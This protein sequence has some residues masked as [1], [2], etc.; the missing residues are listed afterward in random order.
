AGGLT[1][2]PEA[3]L[4]VIAVILVCVFKPAGNLIWP[5]AFAALYGMVFALGAL[6]FA[7]RHSENEKRRE[8][9]AA[10]VLIGLAAITKQE[11][12]LAGAITVTAAGVL[13]RRNDFCGGGAPLAAGAPPPVLV[14]PP[15]F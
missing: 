11:F 15:R 3:A 10:G 8:L 5:Y 6:L 9:I 1:T 2:P 7:L 13:A 12:A 14:A 4:A